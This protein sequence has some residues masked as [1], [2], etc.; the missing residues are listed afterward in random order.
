MSWVRPGNAR[1]VSDATTHTRQATCAHACPACLLVCMHI[2]LC[3]EPGWHIKSI[4]FIIRVTPLIARGWQQLRFDANDARFLMPAA[5]DAPALSQAFERRYS[6]LRVR[7]VVVI[8]ECLR[9]RGKRSV[10]LSNCM[11]VECG[12]LLTGAT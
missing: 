7:G 1:A 8:L 11:Y 12:G 10:C 6:Q 9:H 5:D 4:P 3:V 2:R